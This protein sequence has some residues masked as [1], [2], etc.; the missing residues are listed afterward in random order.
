MPAVGAPF[1][2]ITPGPA[3]DTLLPLLDGEATTLAAW[4]GRG[5][6][7]NFWASW[8]YPCRVEMPALAALHEARGGE[9]VVVG[10]NLEEDEATARAFV[11][12]L[13]LP[14]PILLDPEGTLSD[15]LGVLGLP[16]TFFINAEGQIVGSHLGPLDGPTLDT[17]AGELAPP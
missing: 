16:T 3:P 12:E 4:R 2:T 1:P 14:F 11:E 13:D 8:C 17:L 15:Q 10:V 7:V 6:I 9:V 5:L